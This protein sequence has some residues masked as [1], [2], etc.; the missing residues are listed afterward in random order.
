MSDKPHEKKVV[1]RNRV[2]RHEYFI[3]E[4]FE[5][6]IELTGTEVKSLRDRGCQITEAFCLIRKGECWLHGTHIHPYSHGNRNN[7]DPE[8]KRK[9]L[10]HKKEINYIDRKLLTKGTALIP[11]EMYFDKNNRVKVKLGL[12][13]GKKLYDK[14]QDMA[15][16]DMKRE[17]DRAM[18][19]KN[20]GY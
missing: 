6:G 5:A 8:R 4:V 10:L 18:K 11:L 2:A 7:V 13:R 3:D 9:L 16:R 12:G 1:A 14:R 15:K 17:M 20:L 19:A